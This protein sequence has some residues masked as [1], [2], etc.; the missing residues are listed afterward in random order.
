VPAGR[1]TAPFRHPE[2][3]VQY[4]KTHP[5]GGNIFNSIRHG[6]YL[7]WHFFPPKQV[8]IDGRLII[9]SP[10][11]F[12]EYLTVC[13][14]PELFGG[15]AKRFSI[16]HVLLPT[17]IFDRYEKLARKLYRD[18]GWY[19]VYCD[20]TSVVF[21]QKSKASTP[22]LDLSSSTVR[23]SLQTAV[24]RKWS[25]SPYLKHEALSYLHSTFFSLTGLSF[26]EA[27]PAHTGRFLSPHYCIFLRE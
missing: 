10:E 24:E 16:T 4:L 13:D 19:L 12:A 15:V 22:S 5:V 25:S 8:F 6:G 2:G 3:A 20:E 17:A 11:Y 26:H 14:N 1:Y 27:T 7:L 21:V 23:D 18:P 9:R